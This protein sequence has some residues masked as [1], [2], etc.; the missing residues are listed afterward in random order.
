MPQSWPIP[1]KMG[2]KGQNFHTPPCRFATVGCTY[3]KV[4][5]MCSTDR[6]P[7]LESLVHVFITSTSS[8]MYPQTLGNIAKF[9]KKWENF[10]NFSKFSKI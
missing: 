5:G 3:L 6:E 8:Y 4:C 7:T 10:D 9:S 1:P 2:P